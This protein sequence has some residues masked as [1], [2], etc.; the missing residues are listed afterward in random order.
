MIFELQEAMKEMKETQNRLIDHIKDLEDSVLVLTEND[1]NSVE[2]KKAYKL[3]EKIKKKKKP[4]NH[5]EDMIVEEEKTKGKRSSQ[6]LTILA[7]KK[8]HQDFIYPQKSSDTKM[9]KIEQKFNTKEKL[10]YE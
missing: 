8:R 6:R 1:E 2:F 4:I 7:R 9:S 5:Q 3:A 10:N